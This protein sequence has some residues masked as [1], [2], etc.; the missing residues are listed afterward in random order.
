MNI[1]GKFLRERGEVSLV[2][3][4]KDCVLE[5]E[6]T[7]EEDKRKEIFF[8]EVLAQ[9]EINC[10]FDPIVLTNWK[11]HTA[12]G[13]EDELVALWKDISENSFLNLYDNVET[14]QEAID[15][16]RKSDDLE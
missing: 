14:P 7:K 8:N 5:G 9:D 12:S 13:E 10:M 11:R 3:P 4:F 1:E 15:D 6:Q 2:W 16:F